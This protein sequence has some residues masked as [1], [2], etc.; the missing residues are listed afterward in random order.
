MPE[1]LTAQL[2]DYIALR[3]SSSKA[4]NLRGTFFTAIWV[5]SVHCGL[6]AKSFICKIQPGLI[7]K[8]YYYS[9]GPE[10]NAGNSIHRDI[11][12]AMLAEY[13]P[14]FFVQRSLFAQS[15]VESLVNQKSKI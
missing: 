1:N 13:I 9:F 6:L 11:N 4:V 3:A 12:W 5:A 10:K 15:V 14:R 2:T 7:F 8:F